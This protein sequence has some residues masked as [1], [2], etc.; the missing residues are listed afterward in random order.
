MR[1]TYV[2]DSFLI[3][4]P[5]HGWHPAH[6][7]ED[8]INTLDSWISHPFEHAIAHALPSILIR[9]LNLDTETVRENIREGVWMKRWVYPDRLASGDGRKNIENALLKIKRLMVLCTGP[10]LL[11]QL[12]NYLFKYCFEFFPRH[13]R[14][15][16]TALAICQAIT[17]GT[18]LPICL[19]V[20][21]S[22]AAKMKSS[23]ND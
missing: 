23:G 3:A 7:P 22:F 14:Q 9:A 11:P 1:Y 2:S 5:L 4:P 19:S 17:G 15:S 16:I 18:A 13:V 20:S 8:H 10:N 21:R 6:L 12:T